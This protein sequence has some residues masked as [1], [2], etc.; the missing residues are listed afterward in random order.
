[1]ARGGTTLCVNISS[2]T[3]ADQPPIT[4]VGGR[5]SLV[6]VAQT[7]PSTCNL[8]LR[9]QDGTSWMNVNDSSIGANSFDTYDLPAGE[10]RMNLA[11]G[12]VDGLY[13]SLVAIPYT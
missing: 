9:G 10:Y 8:Q 3:P 2:A 13:A 4:W 5:T 1:M 7:Y 11:G 6:I 12:T